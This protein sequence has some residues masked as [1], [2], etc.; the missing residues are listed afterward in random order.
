[1]RPRLNTGDKLRSHTTTV[2][3][4]SDNLDKPAS[5]YV[6]YPSKIEKNQ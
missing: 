5:K 6:S 3:G 1:L 4:P 2:Q